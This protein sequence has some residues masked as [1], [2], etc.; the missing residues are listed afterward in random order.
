M[1]TYYISHVRLE[2]GPGIH[3][4]N[5]IAAVKLTNGQAIT[6]SAVIKAIYAGDRF[7]TNANPPAAVYVHACPYCRAHD[8]ITTHPDNTTA[9]NLLHLPKF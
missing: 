2:P 5:H 9:N 8:Y 6:R 4:H 1:A 7:Y 3:P